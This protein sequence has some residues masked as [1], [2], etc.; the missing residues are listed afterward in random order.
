[1]VVFIVVLSAS[2]T[3]DDTATD[4]KDDHYDQASEEFVHGKLEGRLVQGLC[5]MHYMHAEYTFFTHG[6]KKGEIL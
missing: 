4:E 6:P 2:A 5:A 1:M 3:R